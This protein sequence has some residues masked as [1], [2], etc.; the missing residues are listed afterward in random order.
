MTEWSPRTIQGAGGTSPHPKSSST[1]THEG[2]PKSDEKCKTGEQWKRPSKAAPRPPKEGVIGASGEMNP[3]PTQSLVQQDH[4]DDATRP[5]KQQAQVKLLQPRDPPQSPL[6]HPTQ[7]NT[8]EIYS[9]NASG[10]MIIT[11]VQGFYPLGQEVYGVVLGLVNHRKEETAACV[12]GN[13]LPCVVRCCLER[14]P[15][16]MVEAASLDTAYHGLIIWWA[17]VGMEQHSSDISL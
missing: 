8:T 12:Y 5:P 6:P 2:V 7:G 4:R 16:I 14:S 3:D 13:G 10:E 9:T 11:T 15:V 1:A 17:C